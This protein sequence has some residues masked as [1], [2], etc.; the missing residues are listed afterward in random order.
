M[1]A[2]LENLMKIKND[3]SEEKFK[4]LKRNFMILDEFC[5]YFNDFEAILTKIELRKPFSI[6]EI[7]TWKP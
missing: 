7:G 2:A 6:F 4:I 5:M 3:F 1:S